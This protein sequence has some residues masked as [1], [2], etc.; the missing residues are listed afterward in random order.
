MHVNIQ[1][2]I[3]I[4]SNEVFLDSFKKRQHS[5]SVAGETPPLEELA[6]GAL[7][8]PSQPQTHTEPSLD[9]SGQVRARRLWAAGAQNPGR[10]ALYTQAAADTQASRLAWGRVRETPRIRSCQAPRA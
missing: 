6:H 3:A 8:L 7:A 9:R 1:F 5:F 10:D 2:P 4:V